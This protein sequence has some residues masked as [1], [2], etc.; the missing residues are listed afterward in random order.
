MGKLARKDGLARDNLLS[1]EI[2][3]TTGRALHA[4]A[5][6]NPDLFWTV[7]GDGANLGVGCWVRSPSAA[8]RA[9]DMIRDHRETRY[10]RKDRSCARAKRSSINNIDNS[11]QPYTRRGRIT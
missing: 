3:T 10:G 4:S 9:T 11:R 5:D 6:E 7:R 8:S 1:V 2:L